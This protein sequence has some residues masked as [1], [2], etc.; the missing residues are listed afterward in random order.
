MRFIPLVFLSFLVS[1]PSI[2][3]AHGLECGG[4]V[5]DMEEHIEHNFVLSDLA[6][7][8]VTWG[9]LTECST[10]TNFASGQGEAAC[11]AGRTSLA[12]DAALQ[13][14][15]F[16]AGCLSNLTLNF[17]AYFD[18][19]LNDASLILEILPAGSSTWE[20]VQRW[21]SLPAL[22]QIQVPL[23]QYSA[24]G[25]STLYVRWRFTSPPSS[26]PA[27]AQ[28]DDVSLL[29]VSGPRA[30]I[31]LYMSSDPAPLPLGARRR[32]QLQITNYGPF[33]VNNMIY[34]LNAPQGKGVFENQANAF[35]SS[36]TTLSK[37][38]SSTQSALMRI[39]GG[40]AT[41]SGFLETKVKANA[42]AELCDPNTSNNARSF[43]F[44]IDP[45]S[46]SPQRVTTVYKRLNAIYKELKKSGSSCSD[47]RVLIGKLSSILS[48]SQKFSYTTM[49]PEQAPALIQ[50]LHSLHKK[51]TALP[52][53]GAAC[54]AKRKVFAKTAKKLMEDWQSGLL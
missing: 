51:R 24:S 4:E 23:T 18:N 53:S 39:T 6:S 29:C 34:A 40:T 48:S 20:E 30:D 45:G 38:Q 12:V 36:P 7:A 16:D 25:L 15:D 3:L 28:V 9:E 33:S 1:A 27:M 14:L 52:L 17:S 42:A 54:K 49:N 47:A 19:P 50:R 11:I 31:N 35:S 5:L 32:I 10:N 26:T 43:T 46:K 41:S 13:S 37:A 22:S 2:A 8:G 21:S 44:R